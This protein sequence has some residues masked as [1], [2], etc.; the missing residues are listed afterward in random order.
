VK[1]DAGAG[2]RALPSVDEVL[3]SS[4]AAPLLR[5]GGR[6]AAR[7]AVRAALAE[8]RGR[9][10]EGSGEAV[11]L[12]GVAQAALER[13]RAQVAPSLREVINATGIIIH[14]GLGRS[15]LATAAQEAIARVARAPCALETD[16]ATGKR[17]SRDLHVRGLLCELTGAESATAVNNNAAAV[18]LAI[19]TLA[20]GRE[21]IV[22]R[23]QEVEI[24]GS[25]RIPDVIRSAGCALVEV[26]TTNRT[27]PRDYEQA[28]G[29]G[30]ALLLWVHPSNYR[31]VGF[32]AEVGLPDLVQLG[33]KAGVPVLADLGSGALLDLGRWGVEGEP[34]VRDAV[35]AGADVV[36]FSADKLLGGPQAGIAVGRA[37]VIARMKRNPLARV[38]RVDKLTLAALEA[39]LQLYR[40]EERAVREIPTLRTIT[41]EAE[42]I[43][44]A[45]RRLARRLEGPLA[46]VAEVTVEREMSQVGGGSL[47]THGLPTTVVSLAPRAMSA[48]ELLAALRRLDPPVIA[49]IRRD[50][51]LLDLRT[52][53]EEQAPQLETALLNL[54]EPRGF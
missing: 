17:G 48:D 20:A 11:S 53:S 15:L 4:A 28:I 12:E 19:N 43:A 25:F 26:G 40:D 46:A 34:V 38:V 50:R 42:G 14:T 13:L 1:R 51:V 45:A 37:E 5:Q 39:T 16:L 36:V 23:G 44:R 24:G 21:V 22:S 52:V 7:D 6:A 47:P 54:A 18:A 32:T 33:R 27:H 30:T 3:R 9:L 31:V 41:R 8:A 2:L 29:E 35:A 10:R 49:R